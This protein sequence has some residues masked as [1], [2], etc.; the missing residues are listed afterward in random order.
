MWGVEGGQEDEDCSLVSISLEMMV[1]VCDCLLSFLT[2]EGTRVSCPTL[3]GTRR[4]T[5][6]E[7]LLDC[8]L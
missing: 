3:K 4:L 7:R 5:I 6:A 8:A 1:Q 2:T